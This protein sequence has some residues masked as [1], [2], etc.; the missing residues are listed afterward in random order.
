MADETPSASAARKKGHFTIRTAAALFLVSAVLELVSIRSPVPVIG[1][2]LNGVPV[3]GYHLVYATVFGVIGYG[4][5]RAEPWA[6]KAV[7]AGGILYSA[8]RLMLALD[9]GSM[10]TY[11]QQQLGGA[12]PAG[13]VEMHQVLRLTVLAYVL[14]VIGWWGFAGYLYLRRAYFRGAQ[15]GAA[16]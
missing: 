8:D 15:Q 3:M 12:L 16:R 11:L 4:L 9:P 10:S 7:V 6:P 1:A 13:A 14:F 5:W 2:V